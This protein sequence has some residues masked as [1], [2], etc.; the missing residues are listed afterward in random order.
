MK[1]MFC[2]T[3]GALVWQVSAA[4]VSTEQEI[5][6]E[7]EIIRASEGAPLNVTAEASFMA[8]K[9][10]KFNVIKK[11]KNNFTC[12]VIS[13]PNGRYEPSC[14]NEQAMRSVY[15]AYELNMRLLYE[16]KTYKQADAEIKS[17]FDRGILPSAEHGSLV[18][19]MSPNNKMYSPKRKTLFE[20]PV[21]QMYYFPK[22]SNETFSLAGK[23]VY[24][25]QGFPHLT[26]LI[27]EVKL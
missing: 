18:Y 5:S 2:L 15:P 26:A 19:M 1:K 9:G 11:G 12:M 6:N 25:W 24:T 23:I 22:L 14:F 10:G 13:D 3:L 20:T 21:H 27:V 7:Q 4:E 17:S 8:F 16:G